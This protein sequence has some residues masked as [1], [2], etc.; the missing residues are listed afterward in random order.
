MSL[1]VLRLFAPIGTTILPKNNKIL[2]RKYENTNRNRMTTRR[3][4][5]PVKGQFP[6]ITD[7]HIWLKTP[8]I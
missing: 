4:P 2:T 6:E 1:Y 7:V 3:A 8:Q 5:H